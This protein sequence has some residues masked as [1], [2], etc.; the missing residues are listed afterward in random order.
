MQPDRNSAHP[1]EADACGHESCAR[2]SCH[3]TR[4]C[5][6]PATPS[7]AGHR[8]AAQRRTSPGTFFADA[9]I[10]ESAGCNWS[11]AVKPRH[12]VILTFVL[13]MVV[14][15][16]VIIA[17]RQGERSTSPSGAVATSGTAADL[18]FGAHTFRAIAAEQMPMV[19]AETRQ[20]PATVESTSMPSKNA[21]TTPLCETTMAKTPSCFEIEAAA[22]CRLPRP[23]GISTLP[24]GTSR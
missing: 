5:E 9:A 21:R 19:A 23:S 16:A 10:L 14:A 12:I 17:A 8:S 24:V 18:P 22:I 2:R 20:G 11:A 4:L 3:A 6:N 15:V 1:T 13:A 7:A